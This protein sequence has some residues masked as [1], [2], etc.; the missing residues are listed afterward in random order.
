VN[1]LRLIR[2]TLSVGAI[3]AVLRVASLKAFFGDSISSPFLSIALLSIFLI[4]LRTKAS[5]REMA[6]VLALGALIY[7]MDIHLLGYPYRWPVL[8]SCIGMASLVFLVLRA[9]W[10]EATERKMAVITAS[11]AFL[12]VASEWCADYFL[13]WGARARPMVLDLYLYT[14]DASLHVQPAILV[15]QLFSRFPWFALVSQL[16]YMGLPVAIGLA[17]AACVRRDPANA[18]P[19]A[20]AFLLTGPIGACFYAM[21]PA[22]GPVHLFL[23]KFPWHTLT[24]DQARRVFLE[25][26]PLPGARNAIPSLHAA[27]VFMAYWYVR[28]FPLPERVWAGI[29][30]FFTLCATLGTGEHYLVDLIVA[31]PF[32]VM[33]LSLTQGLCNREAGLPWQGFSYGL[34]VTLLWFVLLRY[35]THRFWL[36]P[37]LPWLACLLTVIS[38]W[39]FARTQERRSK[40]AAEMVPSEAT[41]A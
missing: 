28:K 33:V 24:V 26:V 31:V 3:V 7:W 11:A 18:M 15:G 32:T 16:I 5:W 39:Y 25:P 20:V 17:F 4:L 21:F 40:V 22:L 37:L 30:V 2:W 35:A 9:I 36:S 41:V 1:S 27:W 12:F 14:F 10:C 8:P 38:G 29:F 23:D 34:G 6:G 13:L 19:A